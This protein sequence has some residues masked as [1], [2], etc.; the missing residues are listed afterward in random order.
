MHQA[1]ECNPTA[2]A[3]S[4]QCLIDRV[5]NAVKFDSLLESEIGIP[6][7]QSEKT[8]RKLCEVFRAFAQ[9]PS[10]VFAQ[11]VVGLTVFEIS[12]VRI[13]RDNLSY[14]F[15]NC[16]FKLFR[17]RVLVPRPLSVENYFRCRVV[18]T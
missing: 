10:E 2:L 6:E 7:V 16:F 9:Q 4:S 18:L 13:V 8:V 11:S 3:G 17:C 12:C 1:R 14:R 15:R 5:P